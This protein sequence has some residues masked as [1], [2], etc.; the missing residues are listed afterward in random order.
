MKKRLVNIFEADFY[1]N[2][3]KLFSY[4]ISKKQQKAIGILFSNDASV[5]L[6]FLNGGDL[7][8]NQIE[9]N[10]SSEP[11]TTPPSKRLL[12]LNQSL[13][14]CHTISGTVE[15]SVSDYSY[16][17]TRKINVYLLIEENEDEQ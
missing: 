8:C 10:Y 12:S 3:V 7:T 1:P 14:A 15:N 2:E 17:H 16:G 9:L 5:S 4:C 13:F 6:S 11:F